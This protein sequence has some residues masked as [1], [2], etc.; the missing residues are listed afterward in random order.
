MSMILFWLSLKSTRRSLNVL[1]MNRSKSQGLTG[2]SGWSTNPCDHIFSLK[3]HPENHAIMTDFYCRARCDCRTAGRGGHFLYVEHGHRVGCKMRIRY[4]GAGLGFLCTS[5][6]PTIVHLPLKIRLLC[7]TIA[8]RGRT[9]GGFL[10]GYIVTLLSQ[11]H[12]WGCLWVFHC[13]EPCAKSA[14]R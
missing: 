7:E 2:Q 3:F 14:G 5:V 13:K 4:G 12:Y 11:I 8:A 6:W 1:K 10:H 9:Q